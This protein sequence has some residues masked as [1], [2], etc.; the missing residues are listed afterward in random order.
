MSRTTDCTTFSLATS[1]CYQGAKHL[2]YWKWES[3]EA[4]QC[5]SAYGRLC[6]R[7]WDGT[8]LTCFSTPAHINNGAG[9]NCCDQS[10][11]A[12]SGRK[13]RAAADASDSPPAPERN[14]SISS[15]SSSMQK[16]CIHSSTGLKSTFK[17]TVKFISSPLPGKRQKRG[18]R[19]SNWPQLELLMF[20]WL[21]SICRPILSC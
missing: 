15:S 13:Q 9:W 12:V 19:E 10:L 4:Q 6:E 5:M 14:G 18:M 7:C 20:N 11:K 2:H 3:L 21:W 1:C 8:P 16:H 17:E